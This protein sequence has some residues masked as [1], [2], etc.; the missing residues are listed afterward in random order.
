M[1]AGASSSSG[2]EAVAKKKESAPEDEKDYEYEKQRDDEETLLEEEALAQGE[3]V[4]VSSQSLILACGMLW[5]HV[6]RLRSLQRHCTCECAVHVR[7]KSCR[8]SKTT[9]TCRSR[10]WSAA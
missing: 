6:C 7:R 9:P 1:E 10:R 2:A 3:D 5:L 4:Q 8:D